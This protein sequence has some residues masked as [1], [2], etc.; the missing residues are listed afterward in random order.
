[1]SKTVEQKFK[2]LDEIEHVLLR[3]GRYLGSVTPHT[4][5]TW[6]VDELGKSMTRKEIT[7]SPALL[8]IFDEIISNSVDFSKTSEGKH[9][10]TIKVNV[11]RLTGEIS[12][13]DNGGIV[14]VKHKEHDQYI[15]EMIFELRAGSNFDDSE[16]SVTTGQNGEGAGLTKIFSSLFKVTTAD[17]KNKFEQTHST[18]GRSKTTPDVSKS[19]KNF[20]LIEFIP[21]YVRFGLESLDEGNYTRIV[22]RVYDVAGCNPEL[23]VYLNGV[24]IKIDKFVDYVNMYID[25]YVYDDNEN[26][27]VAISKSDNGF[28]HVSFVNGTETTIGGNHVSYIADQV[29]TKLREYFNRKHKVDVKP[30]DIKNHLQLFIN[31]TIIRPR[32]SSQTKEDMITEVKNFGTAFEV[33]DKV[34]N[35]LVKS[36]VIQSILDWVAAKQ[37]AAEAA[38]LRKK[39]KDLDKA[40][41]RKIT[42]FTDASNKTD[43]DNCMLMLCEGDSAS[44]SVL[45]ART[46]MIGCYPLKGKPIN[47]MGATPKELMD[48][49]ELVELMTVLGLKIGE[50]VTSSRDLRFGKI[51]CVT[52]SDYDGSH[53][54]GLISAFIRKFWPEIIEQGMFYRFVT[55]IMKVVV[56]KDEKFF[57]TLPEFNQWAAANANTKFVARYLKGLGSSTAKDFKKYFDDMEKHLI[58]VTVS[59][60][61]DFNIVDLVFGKEAGAADKRKVWLDLEDADH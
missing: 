8:K 51:V 37:A 20:T 29:T 58:Q 13:F 1:M 45:S 30:S 11:D 6:V 2:K 23:K 26:W 54:F 15:P 18:N 44:N 61:T 43:R 40:N 55:P 27:K 35:K 36:S 48:N 38:E 52:D 56:G 46:E 5:E 33:T 25:E 28:A 42:K 7:W 3:P 53:I 22:K 32:Y 17:G 4:A 9:L 12:V 34:I 14:V 10:D 21:D 57:Y 24:H 47:A 19:T 60:K 49:K 31:A 39:S 41:L 59:E 50:R 16:D